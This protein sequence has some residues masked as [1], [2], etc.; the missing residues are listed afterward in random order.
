M[1][2]SVCVRM[3][4]YVRMCVRV[5]GTITPLLS[6]NLFTP[7]V[8]QVYKIIEVLGMPPDH[9]IHKASRAEK[10]FE[11]SSVGTWILKRPRDSR[12]VTAVCIQWTHV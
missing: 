8:D 7:Q 12:K 9:I 2:V 5:C 1:C 4:A 10:F 3:W 11:R 6:S